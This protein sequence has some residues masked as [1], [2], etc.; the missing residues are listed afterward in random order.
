MCAMKGLISL[1]LLVVLVACVPVRRLP[2]H[3]EEEEYAVAAQTDVWFYAA[4]NE[5][6]GLFVLPYT[7]YVRVLRRGTAYTYV[8]YLVDEAPY[9]AVTGFCRTDKLTFVDFVPARPYLKRELT[10]TYRIENPAGSTLGNGAFDKVERTF[11]FYGESFAGTA[12][13]Y[14]VYADGVFG[15]IPAT[16]DVLY[17]L[18]DDYLASAAPSP[19]ETQP[20]AEPALT[21]VRIAVFAV[22]GVTLLVVAVF[23]LRGKKAPQPQEFP[24]F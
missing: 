19:A 23:V 11:A 17:E 15:Y 22:V 1:A 20:S 7:Y 2:A 18:N 8:Q 12:R 10:A 14:Y 21:G 5:D 16:Q 6:S 9:K 13:F 3:A 4:E 24:E